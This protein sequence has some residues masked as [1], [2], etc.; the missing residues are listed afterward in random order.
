M[1]PS[2]ALLRRVVEE[3]RRVL[4]PLG[5]LLAVNV[6]VYAL[7]VY[8]LSQRVANIEQTSQAAQERLAAARAD[9]ERAN[10][11]LTGKDKA[12]QE[13]TTFYSS[14]L[15][16]G[17]AGARRLTTLKLL[18]LADGAGLDIGQLTVQDVLRQDSSLKQLRI[19]MDLAGSYS[20]MRGFI[21][22]LETSP[23][24]VVIDNVTLREGADS[25]VTLVVNL[26]LSTY[27]RDLQ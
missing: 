20:D 18:Q 4:L 2:S 1:M 7:V 25:G 27:Y 3:H 21:H 24:F 23:D 22:D 11:T 9:F 15:P 10:A 17:L 6:G 14:V 5:V 13:L 12:S 8:P 16:K 19:Q 26:Q